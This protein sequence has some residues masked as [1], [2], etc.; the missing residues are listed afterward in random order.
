MLEGSERSTEIYRFK[1]QGT[2]GMRV[3]STD[4]NVLC[5]TMWRMENRSEYFQLLA[6][7]EN[8]GDGTTFRVGDPSK[9]N[10]RPQQANIYVIQHTC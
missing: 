10:L 8:R 5:H 6:R 1:G 3:K 9:D 2:N 4:L 7:E